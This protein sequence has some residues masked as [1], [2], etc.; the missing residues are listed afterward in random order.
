MRAV[1]VP[2]A[3]V[4]T[5]DGASYVLVV[6]GAAARRRVVVPGARDEDTG[7]VAITSGLKAGERVIV[8]SGVEIVDGAKITESR[9]K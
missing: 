1:V 4:R 8:T 5:S 3:A 6:D 2:F 9:E 7:M